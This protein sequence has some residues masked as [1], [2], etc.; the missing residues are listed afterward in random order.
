MSLGATAT[1]RDFGSAFQSVE[2]K[3]VLNLPYAGSRGR[4]MVTVNRRPHDF[5][6]TEGAFSV[7]ARMF[8]WLRASAASTTLER[9]AVFRHSFA[10]RSVAVKR[11]APMSGPR[12]V[13]AHP[14]ARTR[15]RG[16]P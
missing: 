1:M 14:P 8:S 11:T 9:I 13:T 3:P 5:V 12:Q 7:A 10:S 2:V 15:T 6:P 4:Y 16:R